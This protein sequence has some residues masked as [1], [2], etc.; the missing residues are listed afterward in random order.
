VDTRKI[1]VNVPKNIFR[2]I[3]AKAK[4]QFCSK[5]AVIRQAIARGLNIKVGNGEAR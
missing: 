2:V 5:G 1:L 4:E 3:D